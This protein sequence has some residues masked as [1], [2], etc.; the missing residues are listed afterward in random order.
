MIERIFSLVPKII[1]IG[2]MIIT[3]P[4]LADARENMH[5]IATRTV[6]VKIKLRPKRNSLS[7]VGH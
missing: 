4:K 5:A 6:P 7:V 2:P 3:P 1:G